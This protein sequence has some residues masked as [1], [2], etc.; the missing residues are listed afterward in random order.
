[1]V[2]PEVGMAKGRRPRAPTGPGGPRGRRATT[3]QR[4]EARIFEDTNAKAEVAKTAGGVAE[5]RV[6]H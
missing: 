4:P 1:M 2:R 6:F 3:K 5:G